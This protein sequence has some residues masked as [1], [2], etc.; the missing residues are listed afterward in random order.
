MAMQDAVW[1]LGGLLLRLW[2]SRFF[3]TLHA[4]APSQ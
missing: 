2:Q 3:S 1:L 4:P